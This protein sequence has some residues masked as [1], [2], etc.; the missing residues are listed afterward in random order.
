MY[1]IKD[2]AQ[3]IVERTTGLPMAHVAAELASRMKPG[4]SV[5]I[6]EV[7]DDE[8]ETFIISYKDGEIE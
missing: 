6:T 7:W 5:Q 3:R 8:P 2:G 4:T 1:L